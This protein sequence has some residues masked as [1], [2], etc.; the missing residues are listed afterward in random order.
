MTGRWLS[1]GIEEVFAAE[2]APGD[3]DEGSKGDAEYHAEYAA[4]GGTPKE[5]GN[6]DDDGVKAG[7]ASHDARG[8]QVAL[9]D[10]DDS[11]GYATPEKDT[12]LSGFGDAGGLEVGDEDSAGDADDGTEIRHDVEEPEEET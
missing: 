6:D 5:D 1:G 8:E 7:L 11:E 3:D 9:D 4:E 10:L 12:P 2:Q